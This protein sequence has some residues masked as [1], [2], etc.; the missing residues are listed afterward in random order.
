M[1]LKP[2]TRHID[3]SREKEKNVNEPFQINLKKVRD[4]NK[5]KNDHIKASNL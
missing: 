2:A 3:S 4:R 5:V 1:N